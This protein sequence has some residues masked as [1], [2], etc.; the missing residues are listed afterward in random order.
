MPCNKEMYEMPC[1]TEIR[2]YVWST[3]TNKNQSL[4]SRSFIFYSKQYDFT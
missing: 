1:T 2:Y 4:K 3:Y